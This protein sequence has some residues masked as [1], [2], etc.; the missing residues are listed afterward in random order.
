MSLG[1]E[2]RRFSRRR[3]MRAM[4]RARRRGA[5]MP[6]ATPAKTAVE[7]SPLL[8]EA[9]GH[10]LSEGILEGPDSDPTSAAICEGRRRRPVSVGRENV[11]ALQSPERP[12]ANVLLSVSVEQGVRATSAPGLTIDD[13]VSSL[14]GFS[15]CLF[16]HTILAVARTRWTS[17]RFVRTAASAHHA[18]SYT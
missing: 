10:M 15:A 11:L 12:H 8:L 14:R 1:L 13:H 4:I 6:A 9:L 18:A 3:S 2:K 7:N 17:P 16:Q 5:P